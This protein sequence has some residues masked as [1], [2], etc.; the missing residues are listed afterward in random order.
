MSDTGEGIEPEH[1]PR[2]L[3]PYFTTRSPGAGSG[4]GLSICHAIV[5]AHAGTLSVQS[6]PGKGTVVKVLLPAAEGA[7]AAPGPGR[8]AAAPRRRVLV[9][10]DEPRVLATTARLL[11]AEFDVDVAGDGRAALER[12]RGGGRYAAILCDLMMP[13]MTGMAFHEALRQEAPDLADRCAF[14]TGGAFTAEARRFLE[15]WPERTLEKPFEVAALRDLVRRLA[16]DRGAG[17]LA[18]PGPPR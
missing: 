12:I 9:V 18:P 3:E 13:N 4:M 5:D 14:L 8:A 6:T 2:V 11:R 15:A 7:A 16:G 17:G 10:D 1:L